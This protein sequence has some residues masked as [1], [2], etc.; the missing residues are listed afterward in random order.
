MSDNEMEEDVI[1]TID[2][3]RLE[4]KRI[5]INYVDTYNGRN[6]SKYLSKCVVGASLEGGEEEAG[7]EEENGTG[8]TKKEN[9][10][11]I[12]G[13]VKISEDYKQPDYIKEIISNHNKDELLEQLMECDVIIY[14]IIH[15][16]DQVDEACWAI[17]TLNSQIDKIDKPKIFILLSTVMTWAKTKP[18]DPEDPDL[19]FTEEDFRRRKC[20]PTYKEHLAAEKTVIKFGKA[21]K[22]KLTTY[23]VCAGLLYGQEESIFH[24][25]F[26]AAW[27][28]NDLCL[29]GNGKNT[30]PTMHINDLAAVIQNI[31]DQKPKARYIVAVDDS[32]PT[33]KQITKAVSKNLGSGKVKPV[34]KEDALLNK[35][36][37][38]SDFDMI[39]IDLK[40]DAAFIKENMQIRW[41]AESGFV[42]NIPKIIKEYKTTRNLI[43]F[44]VCILGPPGV[45]KSTIAHQ[46]AQHYKVHHIHI[47]DV[48]NQ[49]IENLNKFA[50]RTENE[51]EKVNEDGDA[52]VEQEEEEEEEEEEQPDLSELDAI[53]ENMESNNGR[54]DDQYVIKFFKERLMSKPCQNQGFILD[55]FP[56][57]R[58][59][60]QALF[61]PDEQEEETG[62]E[63]GG[64]EEATKFNKLISP[65]IIIKLDSSDDFLCKR[66]MN[67]PEKLVQ[68]THNTEEGLT[69]RLSEYRELNNEDNSVINVFEEDF[70]FDVIKIGPE[71]VEEDKSFLHKNLVD[72]IRSNHMKE[73]RNY[74]LSAAEKAELKRIEIEQRLIKERQEREERERLEA[75]EA[76]ER[77]KKQTEW[78]EKLEQIKKEEVEYLETQSIPL[79]NYLMTHVMPTLTKGLIECCKIKPDDPI[80]YLAEYLFKNNPQVD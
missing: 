45:G 12:Y 50:K 15:E 70:E 74:G 72:L 43:P 16:P 4:S 28:N 79:R 8:E 75:D 58:E 7:N 48:I 77:V 31:A 51:T 33:L 35:E 41:V 25:L 6:L 52:E 64:D 54:L 3:K 56:K 40:M 67:L 73:P 80:D 55:G 60:A 57:T 76:I 14:D 32:K 34:A 68:D 23:V 39:S 13:T 36:I 53:N 62:E 5:F 24:Y 19:P 2:E 30:L 17:S 49:A 1:E 38:Q 59:Q 27:H 22:K 66:I 42:E 46:L 65:E 44:K 11:N 9:T 63:N 71:M 29:Y 47:K 37:S 78:N 21:S 18:A 20:H 69:R 10:Y 26:K 61:E